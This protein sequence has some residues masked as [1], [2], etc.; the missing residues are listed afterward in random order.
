MI[1]LSECSSYAD[2]KKK[3]KKEKF[4]MFELCNILIYL[5]LKYIWN[6]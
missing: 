5:I 1:H 4:S 6:A 3:S 2:M